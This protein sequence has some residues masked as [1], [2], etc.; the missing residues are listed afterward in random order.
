MAGDT[1]DLRRSL[2]GEP[3]KSNAAMRPSPD[4]L[5]RIITSE[6]RGNFL[7]F[8]CVIWSEVTADPLARGRTAFVTDQ[9]IDLDSSYLVVSLITN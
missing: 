4:L 2:D 3:R 1:L 7:Q 6:G 8:A 5:R 9:K